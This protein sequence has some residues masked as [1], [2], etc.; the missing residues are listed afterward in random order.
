MVSGAEKKV[1]G[2]GLGTAKAKETP[3]GKSDDKDVKTKTI[4]NT[5]S[6]KATENAT[7]GSVDKVSEHAMA[8]FSGTSKEV[9]YSFAMK[10]FQHEA[11]I[12]LVGAIDNGLFLEI[13]IEVF[14]F[15]HLLR[16][17]IL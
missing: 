17:Y 2:S 14:F 5:T 13:I 9:R 11:L 16:N 8:Q 1:A 7:D 4:E 12:K 3:E 6:T 15:Q 10:D